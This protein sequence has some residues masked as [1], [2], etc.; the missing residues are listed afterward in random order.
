MNGVTLLIMTATNCGACKGV[1]ANLDQI[2]AGVKDVVDEVVQIGNQQI[3]PP[4]DPNTPGVFLKIGPWYPTVALVNTKDY[5]GFKA[6]KNKDHPIAFKIY[7]GQEVN[8]QWVGAG[9]EVSA[10]ALIPWIRSVS[11]SLIRSSPSDSRAAVKVPVKKGKFC[12][13]SYNLVQTGL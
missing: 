3:Q 10:T 4:R 13:D 11:D 12:G 7:N 2:R 6:T 9:K 5:Q 1:V 8:G